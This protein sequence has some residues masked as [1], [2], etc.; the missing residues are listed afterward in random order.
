MYR[1]ILELII[2]YVM[3]T[4]FYVHE[5][6]GNKKVIFQLLMAHED[7]YEFNVTHTNL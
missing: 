6:R 5:T 3:A 2:M 7:M 1:K 4:F